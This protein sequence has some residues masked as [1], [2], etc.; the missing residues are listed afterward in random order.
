M[1]AEPPDFAA[2]IEA[3]CRADVRFV[4]VGGLAM[5]LQGSSHVTDDVDVAYERSTANY[6]ALVEALG[7]MH[8]R[9]RGAPPDLPFLWDART[10]RAGLNF[11]FDTDCGPV[12]ILGEAA[13]AGDFAGLWE[14]ATPMTLYGHSVRVA[15][16][17]DLIAMKRAANREK[18]RR[19]L[20]ELE[21]LE[22]LLDDT[23]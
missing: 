5:R 20:P 18:D 15:S 4:I 7:P 16:L 14:R 11:T 9:L 6:A 3:L 10:L 12:D 21:A 8:P 19:H 1:P 2:I 17:A 13:G 22:R 23:P